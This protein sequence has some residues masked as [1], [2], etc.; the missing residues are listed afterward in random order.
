[1]VKNRRYRIPL[2]AALPVII[3]MSCRMSVP[4]REMTDAK[5]GI[6]DA[7]K[8]K[9]DKYAGDEL[10]SAV[11]KL[12]DSQD[13]L[14]KKDADGAKKSAEESANL[15]L[16]AY[17][18]AVPLLARDAI[19]VAEKSFSEAGEI[20]ADRLA[21]EEYRE[22]QEK[23][24]EANDLFQNKKYPESYMAALK[25][26]EKAKEARNSA[27]G[28]KDILRDSIVEVKRILEEAERYGAKKYAPDKFN[29]ANESVAI[30][31]KSYDSLELKRGFSAVEVAKLNADDALLTALTASAR[32]RLA[33][34][35]KT[36]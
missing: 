33:S 28:K 24:N 34:A 25:A 32:D 22:A 2:I 18:R 10:E 31:E 13:R 27:I 14:A 16:A 12:F 29:L 21:P 17:N 6:A 7:Q 11:K 5:K 1:M 30:A 4:I 35:E 23:L 9:A 3:F 36:A 19:A 26:D 8:A 20:S 15:A